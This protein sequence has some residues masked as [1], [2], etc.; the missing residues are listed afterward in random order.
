[1][2]FIPKPIAFESQYLFL[3][4]KINKII[5]NKSDDINLCSCKFH[6]KE[7]QAKPAA[8]VNLQH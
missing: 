4:N 6:D 1:L 8:K 7:L 3:N 5:N 2:L